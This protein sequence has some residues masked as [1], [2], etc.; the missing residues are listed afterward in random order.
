MKR[1]TLDIVV[2]FAYV[3]AILIA[4]FIGDTAGI[5]GVAT[6]G[7]VLVAAYYVSFRQNIKA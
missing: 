4:I 3:I 7:A 2:P 6:I 5:G 1:R